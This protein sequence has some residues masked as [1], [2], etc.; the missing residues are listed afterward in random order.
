MLFLAVC[1]CIGIVLNAPEFR[2]K[3]TSTKEKLSKRILDI[4]KLG[5]FR[6][7]VTTVLSL[8]LKRTAKLPN[9]VSIMGTEQCM[10]IKYSKGTLL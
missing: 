4:F 5:N 7:E 3:L 8:Y 9:Y 10:S 2:Q 1:K 6:K